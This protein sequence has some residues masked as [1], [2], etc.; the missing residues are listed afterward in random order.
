MTK[1]QNNQPALDALK[2]ARA[3]VAS[4]TDWLE[5]ELQKQTDENVTWGTVGTFEHVRDNLI[6]TLAFFSGIDESEIKRS[7]DELHS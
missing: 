6:E 2:R 5:R 4:L 1:P 7:L 3:D